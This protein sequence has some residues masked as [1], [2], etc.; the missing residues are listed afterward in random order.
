MAVAVEE[1]VQEL[2]ARIESAAQDPTRDPDER[3]LDLRRLRDDLEV[4]LGACDT[5]L[6]SLAKRQEAEARIAAEDVD[7]VRENADLREE[8][9]RRGLADPLQLDEAGF[10]EPAEVDRLEE[11]GLLEAFAGDL[12]RF[13]PRLHPK[14]RRGRFRETPD[15]PKPPTAPTPLKRTGD[16]LG[17]DAEQAVKELKWQEIAQRA[18]DREHGITITLKGDH[19]RVNGEVREI[20]DASITVRQDNGIDNEVH[21]SVIEKVA[22]RRGPKAKVVQPID[23]RL[24][25]DAR[26]EGIKV[27]DRV[28]LVKGTWAGKTGRVKDKGVNGSPDP[29]YLVVATDDGLEGIVATDEMVVGDV[30]D[31]QHI[32]AAVERLSGKPVRITR[33]DGKQTAGKVISNT[34]PLGVGLRPPSSFDDAD[35]EVVPWS[36]IGGVQGQVLTANPG[37]HKTAVDTYEYGSRWRTYD[38]DRSEWKPPEGVTYA[39]EVQAIKSPQD[40]EKYLATRGVDADFRL[41][42]T[43]QGHNIAAD[44]DFFRQIAQAVTDAQDRYPVLKDG[45]VP[46]R[47]IRL[48]SNI[49]TQSPSMANDGSLTGVWAVTAVDT[50][51][52]NRNPQWAPIP[53][54]AQNEA[55]HTTDVVLI[56]ANQHGFQSREDAGSRDGSTAWAG[57]TPYGRMMHEMGHAVLS[58]SGLTYRFRMARKRDEEGWLI[59]AFGRAGWSPSIGAHL[60]NYGASSPDEMWAEVF[61]TVNVPGA[62]ERTVSRMPGFGPLI[63]DLRREVNDYAKEKML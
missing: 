39:P 40:A 8:M 7:R 2:R 17:Q 49:E 31:A 13:D 60:S 37:Q 10:V 18:K 55:G 44:V 53:Y 50:T 27:D 14:D 45:P 1:W 19:A 15:M 26:A 29:G 61:S 58:A 54:N 5:Y 23:V 41:P 47:N 12:R 52:P 6:G 25:T 9:L 30:P 3:V 33:K 48:W 16:P 20:A 59:E 63:E 42:D 24:G 38:S 11:E 46:F 62:L 56:D 32:M 43:A 35:F 4:A 22:A 21:F 51:E 28:V 36:E 57:L 34:G